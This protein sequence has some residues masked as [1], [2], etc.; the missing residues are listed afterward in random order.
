[1]KLVY[2]DIWVS[3]LKW[4]IVL[5]L[6]LL[7]GARYQTNK[8]LVVFFMSKH[9]YDHHLNVVL[10]WII[11]NVV[12]TC[13]VFVLSHIFPACCSSCLYSG[14]FMRN[15]STAGIQPESNCHNWFWTSI[16]IPRMNH[17]AS[18]F[19]CCAACWNVLLLASVLRFNPFSIRSGFSH[20]YFR[21]H[22]HLVRITITI[23]WTQATTL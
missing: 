19:H 9:L 8:Y 23:P 10:V 18:P 21:Y 16:S 6:Q 17:W 20:S 1:M 14:S 15:Y 22:S 7:M 4:C 11:R 5:V 12:L 3:W 2:A 13:F